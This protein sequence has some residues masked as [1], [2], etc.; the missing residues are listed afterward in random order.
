MPWSNAVSVYPPMSGINGSVMQSLV[1]ILC[2][3][4]LLSIYD[5]A[6][7]DVVHDYA[8]QSINPST[9]KA[10]LSW[11]YCRRFSIPCMYYLGMVSWAAPRT[12]LVVD[13]E[14]DICEEVTRRNACKLEGC[15]ICIFWF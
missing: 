1:V 4:I 5:P 12:L 8:F 10:A 7:L 9:S 13:A 11:C 14:K 6:G 15:Q 3:E 2:Q